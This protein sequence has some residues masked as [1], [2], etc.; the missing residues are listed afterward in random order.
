[1]CSL[2]MATSAQPCRQQSLINLDVLNPDSLHYALSQAIL[3]LYKFESSTEPDRTEVML[4]GQ[5]CVETLIFFSAMFYLTSVQR[6]SG[7]DG[8]HVPTRNDIMAVAWVVRLLCLFCKEWIRGA[9]I[10]SSMWTICCARSTDGNHHS[11]M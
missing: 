2:F 9:V 4:Q 7:G 3:A 10:E 1:M 11:V 6:R 5:R 8:K